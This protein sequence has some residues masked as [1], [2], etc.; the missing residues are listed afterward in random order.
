M[1]SPNCPGGDGFSGEGGT[2]SWGTTE[3]RIERG[4]SWAGRVKA[5]EHSRRL[6][7]VKAREP[8]I[9]SVKLYLAKP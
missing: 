3:H 6:I 8:R 1:A 5:I 4:Y 9:R 2:Y 7:L